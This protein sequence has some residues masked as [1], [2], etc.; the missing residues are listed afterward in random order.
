MEPNTPRYQYSIQI[1]P[2]A[3]KEEIDEFMAELKK[4]LKDHIV[5]PRAASGDII[6]PVSK[7]DSV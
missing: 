5:V 6:L 3:T 1:P 4:R 7:P 2:N